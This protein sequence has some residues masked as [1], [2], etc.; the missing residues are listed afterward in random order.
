MP[1]LPRPLRVA[2]RRLVYRPTWSRLALEEV[3]ARFGNPR[4]L[5]AYMQ[6]CFDYV[7][8]LHHHRVEDHWQDP[9]M[10]HCLRR[11]DC[12]DYAVFAHHVLALAGYESRVLCVFTADE[13]HAL[14]VALDGRR[15]ATLCNEGL[16]EIDVPRDARGLCDRSARRVAARVY[17]GRW[18]SC[19]YVDAEALSDLIAGRATRPF[20]PRYTLISAELQAETA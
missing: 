14:C 3:V 8:D 10:T 15:L 4:A 12:E 19:S 20:D 16:R 13:G 18:E 2:L 11:G 5:D 7:S 17:P 6:V 1:W 9:A